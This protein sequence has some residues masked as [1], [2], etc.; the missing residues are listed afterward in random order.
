MRLHSLDR[1]TRVPDIAL[2][3]RRDGLP[4]QVLVFDAKY[5][6]DEDGR[7][8]P[9]DALADAYAYL[10]AIGCGGQRATLGAVLL[11]PGERD[12]HYA[13]RS[14]RGGTAARAG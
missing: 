6:L 3:I 5:R 4:P 8:V 11:Y 14:W 2:E 9:Q 12:E 10:G 7:G 1:H 13:Q